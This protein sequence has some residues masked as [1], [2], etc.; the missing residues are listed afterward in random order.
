MFSPSVRC[1]LPLWGVFVL[2]IFK[3]LV[4]VVNCKA[5]AS[6]KHFIAS[7]MHFITNYFAFIGSN[8][9]IECHMSNI[10]VEELNTGML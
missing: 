1:F 9:S 5:F 6:N 2:E 3:K 4:V 10:Y 8:T 7:V